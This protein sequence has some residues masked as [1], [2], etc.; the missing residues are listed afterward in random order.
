M[1]TP[2]GNTL[3]GDV[4]VW[5]RQNNRLSAHNMIAR[6]NFNSLGGPTN[7]SASR[8]NSGAA[9]KTTNAPPEAVENPGPAAAPP[10]P[11]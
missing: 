2:E 9:V 1:I 5:D 7:S 6:A 10:P 3:T 4:I 11:P 8:T